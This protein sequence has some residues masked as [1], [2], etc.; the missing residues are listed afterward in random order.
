MKMIAAALRP[1]AAPEAR[2]DDGTA[3]RAARRAAGGRGH[4]APAADRAGR[5][6]DACRAAGRG[7][8][9][10]GAAIATADDDASTHAP[11]RPRRTA[12]GAT[13]TPRPAR[14]TG[15][16]RGR[17][18]SWSDLERPPRDPAHARRPTAASLA[19]LPAWSPS[20]CASP[21]R[22]RVG[23]LEPEEEPAARRRR[24]APG[25]LKARRTPRP[26]RLREGAPFTAEHGNNSR[27]LLRPR[28][29]HGG[30]RAVL[31]TRPCV[32][33]LPGRRRAFA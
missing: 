16:T 26:R 10:G 8:S 24:P 14:T 13:T 30:S 6:A 12:G 11:R 4:G 23:R 3:R 19:R 5:R 15:T 2:G 28:R 21:L 18:S 25:Y 20:A 32:A 33:R 27:L 17:R 22:R 31:A 9:R 29:G 1:R 7:R